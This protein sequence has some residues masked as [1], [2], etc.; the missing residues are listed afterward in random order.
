[1]WRFRKKGVNRNQQG[2]SPLCSHCGSG[3]TRLILYHGTNQ[4]NYIKIWRGQRLLTYRCLECGRDFYGEEPPDGVNVDTTATRQII[5]DEQALLAA[6]EE[7]QKQIDED[8]DRR[9]V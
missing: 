4:P 9:C 1:M 7:S 3:K 8:M 2:F 5:D 6:E